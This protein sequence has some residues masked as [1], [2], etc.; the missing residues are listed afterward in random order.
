MLICC[1]LENDLLPSTVTGNVM[2]TLLLLRIINAVTQ[3]D[4][5]LCLLFKDRNKFRLC[6]TDCSDPYSSLK[7][8]RKKWH[9]QPQRKQ[10]TRLSVKA[11]RC[12]AER[13]RAIGAYLLNSYILSTLASARRFV[14]LITSQVSYPYLFPFPPTMCCFGY[15]H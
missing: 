5:S 10:E 6:T 15:V 8:N 4:V 1:N 2:F 14:K 11:R 3:N 9:E 12:N 7:L 13:I